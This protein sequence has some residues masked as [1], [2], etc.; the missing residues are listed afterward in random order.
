MKI[1]KWSG[2]PISKPGWYSGVPIETYH[3][4][5]MCNGPAVS[6]SG[7]TLLLVTSPAHMFTR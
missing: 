7:P 3:S 2:K 1:V 6:S 4:A 5:G